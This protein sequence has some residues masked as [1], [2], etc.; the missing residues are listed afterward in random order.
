MMSRA[1]EQL[2]CGSVCR[3]SSGAC[4]GPRDSSRVAADHAHEAALAQHCGVEATA[5]PDLP[6][7]RL[8]RQFNFELKRSQQAT[9]R[10]DLVAHSAELSF[11]A[12]RRWRTR[13]G[14]HSE[15]GQV[16][17]TARKGR[18]G[19]PPPADQHARV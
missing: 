2:L 3:T 12:W 9:D 7:C 10:V 17:A 16:L 13:A 11:R 4:P 18:P 14:A 1:G 5:K 15:R 19:D 8:L 6:S